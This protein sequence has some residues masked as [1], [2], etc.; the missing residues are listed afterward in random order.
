[1]STLVELTIE[2]GVSYPKDNGK[3]EA[4]QMV[5]LFPDIPAL[6]T[7]FPPSSLPP[8]RWGLR[9]LEGT[10]DL[11]VA[12]WKPT[13]SWL[14]ATASISWTRGPEN[15]GTCQ[16]SLEN[17]RRVTATFTSLSRELRVLCSPG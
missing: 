2:S 17:P 11:V 7:H 6:S 8:P 3:H 4:Y 12:D 15:K 14:S 10:L 13:N 1:M 9:V 16:N 5:L